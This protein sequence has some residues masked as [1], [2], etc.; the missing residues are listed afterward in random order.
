[1]VSRFWRALLLCVLALALPLQGAAA[2]AMVHCA[3]MPVHEPAFAPEASSHHDA[4]HAHAGAP[5][6]AIDA[7]ADATAVHD[8]DGSSGLLAKAHTAGAG[9]QCSACAAC[10]AGMAI[11][12]RSTVWP[13]EEPPSL[14]PPAAETSVASFISGGLERPPRSDLA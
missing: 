9:H 10:C 14:P 3:A 5:T 7:A 4:G 11:P 2:A 13:A 6:D 8:A 1:M 12:A